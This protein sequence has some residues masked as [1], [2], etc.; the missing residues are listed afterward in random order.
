MAE[1]FNIGKL[2][3]VHGLKGELLLAHELGKKTSLKDLKAV[4]IEEKKKEFLPWFI[5]SARSKSADEIYLKLEGVNT[6]E[7]ALKLLKKNIWITEADHKK[8]A[9]K[10]S[11]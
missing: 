9:A 7:A 8:Y 10:D 11:F 1:Y 6:R 4:F 2:V 5:E 3:A